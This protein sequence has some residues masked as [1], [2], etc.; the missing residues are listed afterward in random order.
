MKHLISSVFF[1]LLLSCSSSSDDNSNQ[2]PINSSSPYSPPAWIH[3]KWGLKANGTAGSVDHPFYQ[4]SS[5]NVCQLTPSQTICWKETVQ[6]FPA[7]Y[8]GSDAT[9]N[10][11][12]TAVFS[13]GGGSTT[14]TLSFQKVS[15]TKI[16]WLGTSSG[17][18]ELE[19][20]N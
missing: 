2:N 13:A 7:I 12:Y 8:S 15:P 17:N 3:G 9:T 10:N 19:K 1:L 4:F 11:T 14:V 20:L 18:V 16:L 6:Q 5:D